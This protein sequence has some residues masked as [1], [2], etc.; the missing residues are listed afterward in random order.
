MGESNEQKIA[1]QHFP[2]FEVS[3]ARPS[4]NKNEIEHAQ[5]FSSVD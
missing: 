4:N 2:V 1:L 3:L 5:F